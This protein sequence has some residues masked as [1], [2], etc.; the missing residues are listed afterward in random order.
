[1]ASRLIVSQKKSKRLSAGSIKVLSP[2]KLNLYLNITG[3]YSARFN[4]IE[5]IV[6]RISLCDELTISR[7]SD[8]L[9]KISC[10]RPHLADADNLC[11]KAARLLEKKFKLK[12]GFDIVLEKRIPVGAGMGGG[13]SNAASTMIGIDALL[14]LGLTRQEFYACGARLGSDVNF[15]LSD[16]PYALV[17]GRGEKIT[18]LQGSRLRHFVVWPG[19]HLETAKV[20]NATHVKLTKFLYNAKILQNAVKRGDF[21]LLNAVNFNVLERPALSLC[22]KLQKVKDHF[23]KYGIPMRLTGSG[24]ALYSF[25][26][27][28]LLYNRI[29]RDLPRGWSLFAVSTF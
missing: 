20:Y 28:K 27:G 29:K 11:V 18:P 7:R 1:M 25:S 4:R 22:D 15:F 24:S 5:S 26:S 14:G 6:E 23:K 10:N 21:G 13:S 17:E 16:S 12:H 2:A 8:R 3:R 19:V 9:I